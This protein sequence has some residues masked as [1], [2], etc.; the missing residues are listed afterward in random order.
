MSAKT[1]P[2]TTATVLLFALVLAVIAGYFA[3]V[4][5]KGQASYSA[6]MCPYTGPAQCQPWR[7]QYS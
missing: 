1:R 2:A 5:P 7:N 6:V 4:H 3:V